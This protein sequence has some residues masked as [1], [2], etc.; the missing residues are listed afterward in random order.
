MKSIFKN[1]NGE[2][3]NVI[4]VAIGLTILLI[5]LGYVFAP[6]GLTSFASVNRTS[7]NLTAG[8]TAGNIWDA[9]V[10]VLLAALILSVVMVVKSVSK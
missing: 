5:V 9:I 3:G 4:E 2:I 8:T 1:D 6:I 7:T 10:P